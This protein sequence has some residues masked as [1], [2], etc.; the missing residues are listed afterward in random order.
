MGY[1]SSE[2]V[3]T[4]IDVNPVRVR[5]KVYKTDE[6]LFYRWKSD[7]KKAIELRTNT[8]SVFQSL[9]K[10]TLL[11]KLKDHIDPKEVYEPSCVRE[12]RRSGFVP[13]KK[14]FEFKHTYVSRRPCLLY[15]VVL[16]EF[17]YCGEK[18]I[19]QPENVRVKT[20]GIDKRQSVTWINVEHEARREF[21][22]RFIFYGPDEK[23]FKKKRLKKIPIVR[24]VPVEA[25]TIY[26]EI[27]DLAP[28]AI[29]AVGR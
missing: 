8:T 24:G 12:M 9:G 3:L 29:S 5:V 20:A 22:L 19:N 1:Y 25:K 27:K 26:K 21:E 6:S 17:C 11:V 10:G 2:C 23:E 13:K 18:S 7:E 14:G 15:H 4:V 28:I 16:P